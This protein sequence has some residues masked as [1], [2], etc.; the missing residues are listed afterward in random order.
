MGDKVKIF[1]GNDRDIRS[2][3][4]RDENSSLEPM[5]FF[6]GIRFYEWRGLNCYVFRGIMSSRIKEKIG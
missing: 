6:I 3:C 4:F 2:H 5:A 1:L